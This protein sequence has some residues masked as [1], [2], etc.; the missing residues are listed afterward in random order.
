MFLKH[1]AVLSAAMIISWLESCVSDKESTI[2]PPDFL[3]HTIDRETMVTIGRAYRQKFPGENDRDKIAALLMQN[4]PA[5]DKAGK[6]DLQE[7]FEK[8]IEA[9]F[10]S[11][12]VVVIA[13]WILA[14]T[15]ARQCALFSIT[16]E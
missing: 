4:H 15:E 8:Q 6:T 11:D 7:Y 3:S 16:A 1:S 5:K 9:E 14:R 12:Q 10:A 13:G 2:P